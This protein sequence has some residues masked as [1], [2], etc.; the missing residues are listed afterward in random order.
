MLGGARACRRTP[1]LRA[2]P[3]SA[4]RTRGRRTCRAWS[5]RWTRRT[6]SA[7]TRRPAPA[8]G[9]GGKRWARADP[10]FIGYTYKNWEAVGSPAGA[11]AAPHK[12][13]ALVGC[14][15]REWETVLLAP[16]V[17]IGTISG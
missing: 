2:W 10:N 14:L 17:R 7:S 1:S 13:Y 6:L 11:R 5:T 9:S 12:G 4:C 3:G 15:C 16:G 8:C